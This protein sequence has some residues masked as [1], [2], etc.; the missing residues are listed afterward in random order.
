MT[1]DTQT[2]STD[3]ALIKSDIAYIKGDIGKI[4]KNIEGLQEVFASRSA[5]QEVARATELRLA[6]LEKE[7]FIIP[8]ITAVAASIITFLAL[9]FL[10]KIV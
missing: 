1:K 5:L 2:T 6:K 7:K 9:S 10:G 4:N 8:S 3:I